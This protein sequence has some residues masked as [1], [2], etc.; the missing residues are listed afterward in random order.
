MLPW[1]TFSELSEV[2]PP[3]LQSSFWFRQNLTRSFY[4]VHFLSW[5]FYGDHKGTQSGLLFFAWKL[6]GTGAKGST[7]ASCACLTPCRVQM[8]L[9]NLSL[10]SDL[11]YKLIIL[12][13]IWQ[14]VAVDREDWRAVIHGVAKSRIRP[15]NWTELN[16]ADIFP[17]WITTLLC[18][19]GFYNQWS[20]K[21]CHA[22][23]HKMDEL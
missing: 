6:W 5:W 19:R 10:F 23:P 1:S 2:L 4:V 21:P 9:V 20:Y 22:G 16:W 17:S 18:W 14:Y 15:S 3:V 11:S 8:N 7:E 12:D 13:F